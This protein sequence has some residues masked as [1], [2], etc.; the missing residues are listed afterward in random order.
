LLSNLKVN[1]N[2]ILKYRIIQRGICDI[3]HIEIQIYYEGRFKFM[4]ETGQKVKDK[5]FDV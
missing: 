1:I 2:N 3:S 4:Y 5:E